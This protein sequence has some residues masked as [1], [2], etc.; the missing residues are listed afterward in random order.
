MCKEL[1]VPLGPDALSAPHCPCIVEMAWS[2]LAIFV[3]V[4]LA[5]MQNVDGVTWVKGSGG[6]SCELVCSAR[7]G[8]TEDAWPKSQGEF[9]EIARQAGHTCVGTQEGGAKYDPSTDGRY[10]GWNGPASA[11]ATPRCPET[12]DSSTFRF[13]PCNAD[14][15]L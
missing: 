15:E 5:C 2:K 13:C 3:L 7:S 10:C 1:C 11:N 12:A 6:A 9:E 4:S 14:K 8:C